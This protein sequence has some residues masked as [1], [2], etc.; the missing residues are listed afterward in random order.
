[1]LTLLLADAELEP[2]PDA[3]R[4][5]SA[6]R[7]ATARRGARPGRPL[8]DSSLHHAALRGVPDGDRRG[9]PDIVHLFLLSTLD[10]ILNLDGGLR[11][12]IH[13]RNDE[14]ITVRPDTRIMRSFDRFAGLMEQV[15]RDGKAGPADGP[16][17]LSLSSGVPLREAV[18]RTEADHTIVLD[19]R[20]PHVD[21]PTALPPV[22]ARHAHLAF[23]LG[24]FPKGAYKSDVAQLG[25]PWS[26]DPRPLSAWIVASEIVAHW[27]HA[28]RAASA[29]A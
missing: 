20:A 4:D 1:M 9:R 2:V 19:E 17:L 18:K 14:L 28:A 25:E 8:L 26:I 13:T 7:A 15:F 29:P 11:V 12:A 24:G 23:V 6:V 10:S 3:I 22:A 21:L 27:R 5:H 16:P